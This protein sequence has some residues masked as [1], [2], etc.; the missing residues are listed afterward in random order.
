MNNPTIQWC[1]FA[2]AKILATSEA[3]KE[4]NDNTESG[5]AVRARFVAKNTSLVFVETCCGYR[6]GFW[7]FVW[8]GLGTAV[9]GSTK[10]NPIPTTHEDRRKKDRHSRSVPAFSKRM[11]FQHKL[12]PDEEEHPTKRI[13]LCCWWCLK[14]F[15]LLFI[16]LL[17]PLFFTILTKVVESRVEHTSM[18]AVTSVRFQSWSCLV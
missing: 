16:L 8:S 13:S 6:R 15:R 7:S 10:D 2:T 4:K 3:E 18:C 9:D 11:E 12:S 14:R 1:R 5:M 17:Q